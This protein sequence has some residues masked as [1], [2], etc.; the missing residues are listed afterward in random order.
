MGEMKVGTRGLTT[1]NIGNTKAFRG[2]AKCKV[3][4]NAAGMNRSEEDAV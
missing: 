2:I 1:E 4:G 3:E